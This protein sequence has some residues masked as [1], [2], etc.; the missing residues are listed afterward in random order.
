MLLK[1][2]APKAV[3]ICLELEGVALLRNYYIKM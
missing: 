1:E 2:A 3:R